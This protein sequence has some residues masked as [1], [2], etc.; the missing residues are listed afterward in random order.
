M[1]F[2]VRDF[3]SVFAGVF[4]VGLVIFITGVT[5]YFLKPALISAKIF[6]FLC[7]ALGVWFT[8]IFDAQSTYTLN[9][10]P[11]LAWMFSPGLLICLSFVFPSRIRYSNNIII[12]ILPFFASLLLFCAHLVFFHSQV[13]WE[14]IDILT[15][16]YV[17]VAT[18]AFVVCTSLNFL[19]PRSLLDRERA[20][21]ILVGA[22]LGF[23]VPSVFAVI[24]TLMGISNLNVLAMLVIFFPLS[25]AYSIVKHK[26]FD[27]D[28]IIQK[29][30]V[31]GTLTGLVGVVF[32]L[33]F[34]ISNLAFAEGGG[35]EQPVLFLVLSGF[36]VLV[37]N[38]LRNR[39]QSVVDTAFFREKY[40]YN[41]TISD[42]SHAMTSILNINEIATKIIN[43][44]TDTMF[45]DS[46]SLL[47]Y[48]RDKNNYR[49]YFTTVDELQGKDFRVETDHVLVSFLSRLKKAIFVEDLLSEQEYILSYDVLKKSFNYLRASLIIPL[50]FKDELVSILSLGEKKSGLMYTSNDL[51]LLKTLGDQTAI[52]IENANAFKLVEDYAKR[53]ESAN[54][55][56]LDT[57]AQL[58]QA[59][60]MS[61]IGQLA[62]GIAHEIRNPLNIIEGARYYLSQNLAREKSPVIEQYLNYIKHEVDRT[63][64]LI[65]ALLKFSKPGST[66]FELVDVNILINDVLTLTRKQIVDNKIEVI[67][68][69]DYGLPK[70]MADLNNIWHVFINVIMN[71]IQA[72]P[73]GGE[74]RVSTGF[75]KEISN[76]VFISFADNGSGIKKED[77][78]RIFD[79]FFTTKDTGSGLGLSVSYKIVE[80]HNG[81]ITIYSDTEK[82]TKF[83][84][85]LPIIQEISGKDSEPETKTVSG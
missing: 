71:S 6:F 47:V 58:I 76:K 69:L 48:D 73:G 41:K 30:L 66:N 62:A 34:M 4:F 84:I 44:I 49:L 29:A 1:K 83:I 43:T 45:I 12:P 79:P 15:W 53:L 2:E 24:F 81:N 5:V 18:L 13:V 72:M 28:A 70:I 85:E 3:L 7:F 17:L 23:L 38:P 51:K 32:V 80:A 77:L 20:K 27:I 8:T 65:D 19:R 52:A 16:F 74:L 35:W 56:L 21:V 11:F 33:I 25:I 57:Q 63:N 40:D 37:I 55:E 31:Y 64:R 10:I 50:F 14:K 9:S 59:E 82:G 61:A 60:K 78:P 68:N 67:K 39:V 54:R 22:F 36:L 46:A 26:L 42:L 75:Q